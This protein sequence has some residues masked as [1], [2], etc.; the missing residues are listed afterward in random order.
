MLTN[1]CPRCLSTVSAV[2]V[3]MRSAAGGDAGGVAA[4][5]RP[6]A[7]PH[8]DSKLRRPTQP[9]GASHS[10]LWRRGLLKP[11]VFNVASY[12]YLVI[13]STSSQRH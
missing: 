13:L 6:N 1:P 7:G 11:S 3:P 2:R 8:R 5:M 9:E 4:I 12:R 10:R